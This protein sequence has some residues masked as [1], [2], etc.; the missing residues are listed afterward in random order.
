MDQWLEMIEKKR[1]ER[2][3]K[4]KDLAELSGLSQST[5]SY[6]FKGKRNPSQL[7]KRLIEEVLGLRPKQKIDPDIILWNALYSHPRLSKFDVDD[8]MALINAKLSRGGSDEMQS[9]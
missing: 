8:I 6:W 1:I 3:L 5:I 4:R 9:V 2:G 7:S